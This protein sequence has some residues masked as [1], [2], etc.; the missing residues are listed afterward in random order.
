MTEQI[1]VLS[2]N[3]HKGFSMSQRF[4]LSAIKEAIHTSGADLVFLQEVIGEHAVHS[5][6]IKEWPLEPQLEFL[7]DS[8]WHHAYGKN[9]IYDE[10]HHGNAIL[11]KRPFKF[12]E[13]ID[14]SNS[15]YERRGLLHATFDSL[16]PG[17]PEIH[18]VCVHLDLFEKGRSLQ[19]ERIV[20]RIHNHVPDGCPLIIAGDFND[21][22]EKASPILEGELG[23]TEV[24]SRLHGH[25]ALSFP[26]WFPFLPLDRIYVRGVQPVEAKCFTAKPWGSLSDHGALFAVL[27]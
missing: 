14:I 12:H 19:Y 13:N 17:R 1:K 7:A 26:V 27:E 8:I 15:K 3:I 9:A 11:S 5:K 18:V 23:V 6:K 25:H 20:K 22:R 16:V 10:G 4:V 2:Y 24:F 21:W